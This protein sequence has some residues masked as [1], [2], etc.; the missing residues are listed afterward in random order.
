MLVSTCLSAGHVV[1]IKSIPGG[2]NNE[3]S[4]SLVLILDTLRHDVAVHMF[5]DGIVRAQDT[6]PGYGDRRF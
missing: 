4:K 6:S 2:S 3:L 1:I 5:D